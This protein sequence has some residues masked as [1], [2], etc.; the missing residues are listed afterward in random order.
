MLEFVQAVGCAIGLAI[1]ASAMNYALGSL[2]AKFK[3]NMEATSRQALAAYR[4]LLRAQ[5]L[6]FK[7]D[8]AVLRAAY[9]RTR[10]EYEDN[11]NVGDAV[12]V[13]DL[14]VQANETAEFVRRLVVQ[15]VRNEANDAYQLRITKDTA[16]GDNESIKQHRKRQIEQGRQPCS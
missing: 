1:G 11:R 3:G 15:G 8:D 9:E 13:Q 16:L 7:G 10:K 5:R 12:K 14:I 2:R 4:N 6:T